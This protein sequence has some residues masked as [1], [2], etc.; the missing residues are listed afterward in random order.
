M[1]PVLNL[2]KE[3]QMSSITPRDS[4]TQGINGQEKHVIDL[5]MDTKDLFESTQFNQSGEIST[6]AICLLQEFKGLVWEELAL[7]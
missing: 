3:P 6:E 2:S 7:R 5:L 1:V 4:Y